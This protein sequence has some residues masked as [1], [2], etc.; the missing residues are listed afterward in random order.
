MFLLHQR[1]LLRRAETTSSYDFIPRRKQEISSHSLE[2]DLD[3]REMEEFEHSTGGSRDASNIHMQHDTVSNND[4]DVEN[5]SRGDYNSSYLMNDRDELP[6]VA[7]AAVVL[8]V[9]VVRVDVA[10]LPIVGKTVLPASALHS[11]YQVELQQPLQ[12]VCLK[13]LP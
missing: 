5:V 10:V 13:P 1:L 11:P 2:D 7:A 9:A 3:T 6:A 12:P 4:A 8:V